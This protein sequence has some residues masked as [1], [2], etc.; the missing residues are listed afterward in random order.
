MALAYLSNDLTEEEYFDQRTKQSKGTG[1]NTRAA[2]VNAKLFCTD[3]LKHELKFVM[4]EMAAEVKKT[5]QL[6]VAFT[7]LQKFATWMSEPHLELKMS[8][9]VMI[10]YTPVCVAKDV[11]TIKG[12]VI[13]LRLYMK[14]VASIPISAEDIKDNKISYPEPKDKEEVE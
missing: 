7:F 14:K 4:Q 8:P 5:Q 9:S 10:N 1:K 6:N 13:Q 12:Y 11:D 2:L 3:S